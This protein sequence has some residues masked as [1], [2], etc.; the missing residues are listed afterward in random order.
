M[1]GLIIATSAR[2]TRQTR[3]NRIKARH[4]PLQAKK[5]HIKRNPQTKRGGNAQMTKKEK[6]QIQAK[7]EQYRKWAAEE[8][9]EARRAADDSERDEHRLQERLN[10][11]AADTLELLLA[12]LS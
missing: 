8:A 5:Q 2:L 4:T 9:A 10:D 7:I 12:E 1:K 3:S 11:S 6:A